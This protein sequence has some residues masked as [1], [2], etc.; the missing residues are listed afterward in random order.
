MNSSGF[1]PLLV[2]VLA[3]CFVVEH[4]SNLSLS[5][6]L[7]NTPDSKKSKNKNQEY[8]SPSSHLCNLLVI[9]GSSFKPVTQRTLVKGI[10][11][12]RD[13]KRNN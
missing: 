4:V 2:L 12:N 8:M 11:W 7:L 1:K 3:H 13:A 6:D 10:N 5:S 9:E